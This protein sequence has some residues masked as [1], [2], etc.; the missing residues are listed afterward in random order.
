[1]LWPALGT[2]LAWLTAAVA[3]TASVAG[4]AVD[5][6]YGSD[7]ATAEALRAYDLVTAVLVVPTLAL[8]LLVRGRATTTGRRTVAQLMVPAMLATIVYTYAYHLFGT[9]FNDLFLLHAKVFAAALLGLVITV[10]RLDVRGVAA[11][12]G[13]RARTRATGAILGVLAIAL[14]GMWVGYAIHNAI[15]GDVPAGSRLVE[16]DTVVHLGMALDLTLLVPLYGA[17]AV[18]LWLRRPWGYVLGA[19]ALFAGLVH[20][21]SY[22]VAMPWQVAAGVP[23]AVS[24]DPGEP[25]IVLLY[26]AGAAFLVRGTKA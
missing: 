15:T 6:V 26:V 1:V 19:V 24:L 10:T 22:V 5:G 8:G 17:A 20:Q 4:L 2:W 25:V 9:G 11:A 7:L 16:S 3:L 21:V 12:F 13:P 14:A 23:G 18:L